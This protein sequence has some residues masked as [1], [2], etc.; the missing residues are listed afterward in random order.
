[1]PDWKET[2]DEWEN[3]LQSCSSAPDLQALCW[4]F[5][6]YGPN[7]PKLAGVDDL[8]KLCDSADSARPHDAELLQ[9]TA[10]LRDKSAKCSSIHG[11]SGFASF[12]LDLAAKLRS[13]IAQ[14][15]PV[16]DMLKKTV[17]QKPNAENKNDPKAPPRTPLACSRFFGNAQ[18]WHQALK[19]GG[20]FT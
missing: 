20:L 9:L 12:L 3:N 11:K 15:H 17:R 1:M 4:Q 6:E 7:W 2:K 18:F 13:Q 10:S 16:L 8:R 14:S 5:E 19:V